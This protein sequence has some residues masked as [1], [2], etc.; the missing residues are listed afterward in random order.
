VNPTPDNSSVS[1]SASGQ[2]VGNRMNYARLDYN[3]ATGINVFVDD[4]TSNGHGVAANFNEYQIATDLNPNVYHTL[5][6]STIF[7]PGS[8]DDVV[9]YNIDGTY[10]AV[11]GSWE[12]YYKDDPENAFASYQTAPVDSVLFR[13]GGTAV[14]GAGGFYFDNFSESAVPE[15]ASLGLLA[16]GGLVLARRPRRE[17][18]AE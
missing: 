8:S 2:G 14:P 18:A 11:I 4:A 13:T 3:G 9:V 17:S 7:N 6:V 1:L 15:P 16:L 5:T 10:G 12:A